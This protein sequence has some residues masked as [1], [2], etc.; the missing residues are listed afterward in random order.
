MQAYAKSLAD[1][2][3]TLVLSPTS[4]FFKYFGGKPIEAPTGAAPP[5]DK[6][7]ATPPAQSGSAPGEPV[8][9]APA[10]ANP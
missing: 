6:P 5:A 2:G 10:A 7:P 1:A 8:K 4:E 9:E 3:T